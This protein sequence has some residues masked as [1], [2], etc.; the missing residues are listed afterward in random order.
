MGNKSDLYENEE[1]KDED[2]M[3]YAKSI[4]AT[5][6]LTSAKNGDN[7][8]LLFDT[9][10]RKFLGPEFTKKVQEMKSDKGEATKVTNSNGKENHKKKKCC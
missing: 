8:D 3:E 5:F 2:A 7:I 4:G 10:T 6:V 1:V 9:L